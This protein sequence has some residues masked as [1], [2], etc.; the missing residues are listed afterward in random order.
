MLL[1]FLCLAECHSCT[2]GYYCATPGLVEPTAPCQAGYFCTLGANNSHPIDGATGDICPEGKYCILGSVTGQD[3]PA[4]RFGNQ[5]GLRAETECPPCDPGWYCPSPGLT[6]P[7][8]PC[9]AGHLCILGATFATPVNE[10]WGYLCPSGHYCPEGTP[11]PVQCPRGTFQPASGKE[12]QFYIYIH[13][14]Y[15][16]RLNE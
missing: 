15:E 10:T 6:T 11:T 7:Y 2:A 8:R 16:L 3:C 12:Q 13:I 9:E 14:I 1:Y 5:T 4:G